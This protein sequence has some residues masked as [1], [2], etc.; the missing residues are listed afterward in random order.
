[1]SGVFLV[2]ELFVGFIGLYRYIVRLFK[3]KYCSVGFYVVVGDILFC[4]VGGFFYDNL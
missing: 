2:S 1:M 3:M 4:F